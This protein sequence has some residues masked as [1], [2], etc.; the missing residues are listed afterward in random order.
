[1]KRIISLA[2]LIVLVGALFVPLSASARG[3]DLIPSRDD[4]VVFGGKF[5]LE[6]GQRL[7]GDLLSFGGQVTLEEGSVVTG[8][9]V[10]MGG[11]A[12]VAGT[13]GD[14]LV[15]FGAKVELKSMAV[16]EGDLAM[17][18]AELER[19]SGAQ[20][21]GD[22]VRETVPQDF[23]VPDIP[24][25][26]IGPE[27]LSFSFDGPQ[28]DPL[29]ELETPEFRYERPSLASRVARDVRG[30]LL[31]AFGMAAIAVI[32][33]LFLPDQTRRVSRAALNQP[34]ASGGVSLVSFIVLPILFVILAITIILIPVVALL[35][36]AFAAAIIFGWVA[37]GWELGERLLKALN[38]DWADSLQAGSGTFVLTFSVSLIG[39]IPCLG[40]I[41]WFLLVL[42]S[43]GAVILTR[44]GS[45]EY[46]DLEVIEAAPAKAPAKAK[47]PA[48][49]KTSTP[50]K[51]SPAKKRPPKKAS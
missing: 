43:L 10:S 39:L 38:L 40:W 19:D 29:P 34:L 17:I 11:E 15:A 32:V 41:A 4:R 9:F 48:K 25:L 42:L 21:L 20:V 14:D 27:G 1:M 47:R 7:D 31:N 2:L 16:V 24:G 36:M 6:S 35:A 37:L 18:G 30:G 46:P 12:E 45:Q 22:I 5:K 28:L 8:S 13:I 49:K 26:Q 33:V 51:K 44:F 3:I 23:Q 50:K